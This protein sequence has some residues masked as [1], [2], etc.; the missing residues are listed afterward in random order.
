MAE[1]YSIYQKSIPS[2]ETIEFLNMQWQ[3]DPQNH[4]NHSSNNG[5]MVPRA[6]MLN[7]CPGKARAFVL[8]P[9]NL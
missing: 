5:A 1:K 3:T 9:G 7:S 4:K 8:Y 2:G 6:Q